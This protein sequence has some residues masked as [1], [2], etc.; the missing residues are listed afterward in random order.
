MNMET[1]I[2]TGRN[3]ASSNWTFWNA[4]VSKSKIMEGIDQAPPVRQGEGASQTRKTIIMEE[5]KEGHGRKPKLTI[6]EQIEHL[7]S[8]G[9]TFGLCAE[10]EA[11]RI[12]SEQD[13]YFRLAAYRVLFPKRIGG[14]RDGEYAGLDFGHLVDLAGI[15]QELR[16][17]LLPLTL[18]VENAAK[19]K[20]VERITEDPDEDGYSVFVDYLAHLNHG[21]RNRRRGEISRLENDAYLGPLVARYPIKEMPAWVFL[22]LSSFG[23]FADFYLFCSERWDDP[24]MRDEHYLLRRVSSLRNAAAHSSAM[25]NGL[26]VG[27][28]SL[29]SRPPAMVSSALAE[30]GVSRRL[31]RARLRNPRILQMTSL[32]FA[33]GHFVPGQKRC[34][35][36]QRLEALK[37]RAKTNADWYAHSNALVASYRFLEKVFDDW[38][39]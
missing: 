31:R 22:E 13:H 28:N 19:T 33:H 24:R 15:D 36:A 11:A 18:D 17:F 27:S 6:E 16:G 3:P 25:I 20:L 30:I 21:D 5:V 10:A 29:E 35:A 9:V 4:R 38:L 39:A 23:A 8:K 12:L 2:E 34:A 37:R 32:A 1:G 14:E 7:K 26:G